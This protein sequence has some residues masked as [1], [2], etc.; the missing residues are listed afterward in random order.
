MNSELAVLFKGMA[1]QGV[2]MITLYSRDHV[3][4]GAIFLDSVRFND[5]AISLT[6]EISEKY[7]LYINGV[8]IFFTYYNKS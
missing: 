5:L 4:V 7:L 3:P 2:K 6:K 8:A 1:D